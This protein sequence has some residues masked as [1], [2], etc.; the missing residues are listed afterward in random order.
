MRSFRL[1]PVLVF[2]LFMQ[3]NAL[4]Q[5][6]DTQDKIQQVEKNLVGN[7]QI[8]GKAPYTMAERMAFYKTKGVSVAVIQNYK[9]AWAKGYG[10]ADDSLK[11]PVT[12]QT[13]FQAASISKS[14][15]SVGALRLVQEKKIDLYADINNYL[16]SWKFPYDSLSGNK[17]ISLANLLSHTAGLT[18]HGFGGYEKGEQV[19]TLVQVLNGQKPAN[20]PAV[21]SMYAP[22]LKSEYSGGGIT[23]SQLIVM[24][25]TH[26]PYDKYM[27]D[28]VLKP[29]GMTSST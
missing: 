28:Q 23:I 8:E 1:L 9:L 3:R 25:V 14:L 19:P 22:G 7:V 17:K 6:A 12:T 13:L 16:T 27:Y 10:W 20:S 26:Q 11:I 4:G 21:R 18:V 15:N 24:D 2:I 5:S 29:L